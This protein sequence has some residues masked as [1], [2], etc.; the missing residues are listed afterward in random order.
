MDKEQIRVELTKL[1][2][3]YNSVR[4]NILGRIVN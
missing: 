1:G 4:F 2:F 3:N